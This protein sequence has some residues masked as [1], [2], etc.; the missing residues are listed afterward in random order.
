MMFFRIIL[1]FEII[2]LYIVVVCLKKVLKQ[3]AFIFSLIN[4]FL[5]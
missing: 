3:I 2:I 5:A 1:K 4:I